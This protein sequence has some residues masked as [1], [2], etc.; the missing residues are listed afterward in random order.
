VCAELT[1]LLKKTDMTSPKRAVIIPVETKSRE[2]HGK[3]FLAFHLLRLGH[4]VLLGEQGRLW[5]YCDLIDPAIYLDKSVASTRVEWF[6]SCR[7]MGHEVVS[8]DE[9]GLV[10]FNSWLYRKQRIDPLAFD[11]VSR[12]FAWGEIQ[13]EA[14]CEE[15]PQ[16]RE[17]IVLCGNP[18]F[19]L[20]RAEMREFYRPAVE[21][22]RKRFGRMLLINTNFAFHNHYKPQEELCQ[23]LARYPIANEPGYMEKWIAMHR[24]MH[25]A[26]LQMVPELLRRYP[27][28]EIV[29]RPHPSESHVPWLEL[30]KIYPRLHVDATGNVHEWILASEAVVHFNCT[31][32]VESFLLDVPAV[33][34]R[35]SLY[36]NYEN[37]LPNSLSVN[38]FSLEELFIALDKRHKIRECGDL[39]S[40]KQHEMA[41]IYITGLTGEMAAARVAAQIAELSITLQQPRFSTTQR[42]VTSIKRSW[43]IVL[44]AVRARQNKTDGYELQKFPGISLQ[45]IR[46][47]LQNVME[48][49]GQQVSLSVKP[50]VKNCFWLL[51][52]E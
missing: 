42:I 13:R 43:R 33:A 4:P 32:A 8:W 36:P 22:L 39:W 28:H 19:D 17:K 20:L 24:E 10:F 21:S 51:P 25:E 2:F 26:Y 48:V 3:L 49:Q 11:Q 37:Q 44:H 35:P 38:A 47:A 41:R 14:I 23:L 5:N 50:F 6:R 16:Y 29:L 30:A 40:D 7:A 34:Y 45:E 1:A 52:G 27:D 12:F 46:A 9:E 18:R 31:T 15:Y